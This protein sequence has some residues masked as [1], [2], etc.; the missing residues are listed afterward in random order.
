[1]SGPTTGETTP[2]GFPK[3]CFWARDR[4]SGKTKKT[5]YCPDTGKFNDQE[6]SQPP[7]H[8][9]RSIREATP[10]ENLSK[11]EMSAMCL[12]DNDGDGLINMVEESLGMDPNATDSDGDGFTDLEE[13]SLHSDPLNEFGI[14][15]PEDL[16]IPGACGNGLDDDGDGLK[17]AGDDG[18]SDRDGDGFSDSNDNCVDKSNP[19]QMDW[20]GD[21]IG[22]VC[23]GDDDADGVPDNRDSCAFTYWGQTVDDKGC[24]V[25]KDL[26]GVCDPGVVNQGCVGE[27]NCP[28]FPNPDQAD[29]DGDGVGDACDSKAIPIPFPTLIPPSSGN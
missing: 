7:D 2:N 27:D 16:M 20:D 10:T 8:A 23:D 14:S 19:D 25:D 17:D 26:D 24:P 9:P 12:S 4:H 28:D 13:Y 21:E 22:A 6:W 29:K 15:T 5:T 1:M 3:V 18:C 11:A